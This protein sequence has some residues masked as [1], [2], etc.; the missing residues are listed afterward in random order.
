MNYSILIAITLILM[1]LSL[2]WFSYWQIRQV[3]GQ[4]Y[5]V[6]VLIGAILIWGLTGFDSQFLLDA[7]TGSA[8]IN[9]LRILGLFFCFTF[10]A[11]YLDDVG[12]IQYL[13]HVAMKKAGSSQKRLFF[14]WFVFV[15]M[16]T[17]LTA[18]DIV[19]LT[20]TPFMI[21][22][23]KHTRISP[24]PFLVSQFVAANTWSM[25][26]VIGN[27]TNIYLASMFNISFMD[28]AY[29]MF[30]PTLL[31]G[32]VSYGLLFFMFKSELSKPLIPS[33]IDIQHP[34]PSYR[35]GI[36][37]LGL[38]I[39]MMAIAKPIGISMDLVTI[40]AA[41]LL[42][43]IVTFVYP[44]APFIRSTFQRLPYSFIPFF[45]GMAVLVQTMGI[46]D[47][48][49]IMA[50]FLQ[51]FS[52]TFSF[53]ISSFFMANVMNNIPMSLWFESIIQL[54]PQGQLQAVYASII[55]SNLGAI[56][57]PVGALAGLMWM[58]VLQSKQ[59]NYRIGQFLKFGFIFGPILLLVSLLMLDVILP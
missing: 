40:I 9:P 11:I 56:L 25:L 41:S 7:W 51:T 15:S 50:S 55:G 18:N 46:A 52:P 47:W 39:V 8:E 29:V 19:I 31:T 58:N 57:T 32:I 44:K 2:R 21:Y 17:M 48:T 33:T 23:A 37:V 26:L 4:T 53:G 16:A 12:Y 43:L 24:I 49:Q 28:Y 3:R 35:I 38:A 34:H 54:Q 36:G 6:I 14:V 5:W 30:L 59:I 42:V 20:L 1:M 13:A 45:L 22:F 10:M 27:P